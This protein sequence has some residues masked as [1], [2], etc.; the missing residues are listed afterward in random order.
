[1]KVKFSSAIAAAVKG[2]AE[3][4]LDFEGDIGG[5]LALLSQKYGE[6]FQKRILSGGKIN[7][8]VSV[9]ING[10]D[11]RFLQDIR[12]RV[13]NSDTVYITPAVSGG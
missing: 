10:E 2:E 4:T 5:L 7:G 3:A 11:I 6:G 12:T 9:Y 8:F 13:R 1:M